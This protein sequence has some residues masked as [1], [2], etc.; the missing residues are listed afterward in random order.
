VFLPVARWAVIAAAFRA[1]VL[2]RGT[3]G[4]VVLVPAGSPL[5]FLHV[6]VLVDDRHH[7]AHCLGVG[8]EH[9]SPQLD[10]VE[11]LVEVVDD[12]PV[13]SFRNGITVSEVPLDVVAEG[14][15]RLLHDAA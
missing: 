15:V 12:I 2:L 9:L 11:A 13:I 6:G 7:L 5:S 8:L 14:L 1:V 3:L 10:I 4:V